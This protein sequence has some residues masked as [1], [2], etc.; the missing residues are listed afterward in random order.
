[1]NCRNCGRNNPPNT[2]R[3]VYCGAPLFNSNNILNQNNERKSQKQT[4]SIIVALILIMILLL[5]IVVGVCIYKNNNSRKVSFGGGSGGGG[6]SVP[7]PPVSTNAMIPPNQNENEG[8]YIIATPTP[9]PTA[10]PAPIF[11]SAS[12]SSIRGT[13]TEGGQYSVE[14]V[15][16]ED[17]F[18]KWVP[19]KNSANGIG[20]WIEV[21]SGSVQYV[22]GIKILNGYHKSEET[23][24]N[25]NRV[26]LCTIS[27]SN[28]TSRQFELQDTFDMIYLDLGETIET[29]YVRLTINSI[30]S[31]TK[32]ND[33]A[34]TYIGAY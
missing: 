7:P 16:D 11:S 30:Y 10:I 32:W 24:R 34:I 18:T 26:R 21:S 20:E 17:Y 23:W 25:N 6:G 4:E 15:L 13:D 33:T 14:A 29:S 5:V 31:G 3:C 2:G 27:F 8:D 9:S 1:M 22:S 28:G 19:S 12:A